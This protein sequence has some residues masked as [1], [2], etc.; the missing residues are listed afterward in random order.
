MTLTHL[1]YYAGYAAVVLGIIW[2]VLYRRRDV[3][4]QA[5]RI[6]KRSVR[7]RK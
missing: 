4:R 2:T 3:T 1:W 6:T 5:Q 7:R